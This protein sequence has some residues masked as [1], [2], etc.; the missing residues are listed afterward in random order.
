MM[1]GRAATL[2]LLALLAAT[3]ASIAQETECST[4]HATYG[5]ADDGA[6]LDF[7]PTKDAVTVTNSFKLLLDKGLTL[8]GIVQWSEIVKRPYGMLMYKCPEGDVTGDE[9]AACTVWQGVIYTVDESGQVDLLSPED[10]DPPRT[11]ILS[12]LGASLRASTT[13]GNAGFMQTLSDVFELKSCQ[14]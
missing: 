11:L 9:I 10:D 7:A 6:D 13:L 14:Q 8:D 12:D 1:A 2:S 5:N 4:A 3:G